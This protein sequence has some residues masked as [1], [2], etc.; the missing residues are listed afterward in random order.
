MPA[1]NRCQKLVPFIRQLTGAASGL[2]QQLPIWLLAGLLLGV[3]WWQTLGLIEDDRLR[4]ITAVER[5]L[6]NLGRANQEHAERTF[7]SADQV[8]RLVQTQYKGHKGRVTMA[9]L[10]EQG[11]FDKRIIRDVGIV[12]GAGVLRQS[13]KRLAEPI[14]VSSQ[15]YFKVHRDSGADTLFIARPAR[16]QSSGQ[17]SIALSRRVSGQGGEFDGVVV[18]ALDPTYFTQY[19][20]QIE[21][22]PQGVVSLF[23]LDGAVRARSMGQAEDFVA[24]LSASPMLSRVA[25][26]QQ[27]STLTFPGV[28]DGVE[29]TFHFRKLPS[30]PMIVA[31][32]MTTEHI[33]A[34]HMQTR[35]HLLWHAALASI[36]L[37]TL[38][39]TAS[40]NALAERRHSAAQRRALTQLQTYTNRVPGLVYEYLQRPDGSACFPFASDGIQDIL[41]LRAQDVAQ[42]AAPFFSLIHPEDLA[43]VR[44][45]LQASALALTPWECEYRVQFAEGSVRWLS[46]KALPQRL[47]DGALQWHGFMSDITDKKQAAES[48]RIAATAFESEEGVFITSAA[49][50]ILRVNQAFSRITGYQAEEVIGQKPSLLSSGRHDAAFYNA[51]R[52]SIEQSGTWHGEIWNRRKNGEVFPEWLSITAV[53][54]DDGVVT[55]HVSTLSDISKRK[56]DEAEIENLAF[57]DSLTGLPNRRLLTDRLTQAMAASTGRNSHGALLFVDL[58]HFKNLNDTQGHGQGDLLL[59]LVA[60]R[61]NHCVRESDTVARMGGDDFVIML[62]NL[63]DNRTEAAAQAEAVGQKVLETLRQPFQFSYFSYHSGASIGVALF[64]SSH[65]SV[66]ELFKRADLALYQAKNAGR[67]TLRFFEPEMQAAMTTRSEMEADLRRGL[68]ANQFVLYYQPQV[69]EQNRLTGVEALVRWQHPQRGMVSPADFIPL[70]EETGLILPLGQW[71]LETAC[72]QLKVWSTQ[73]HTA[74]LTLAVNVSASQ[75][76]SENYVQKVL[77]TIDQ[78]GAPASR[79]KLELTESLL[80]K[81]I[82]D[83]IDKMQAL[84]AR[85]VGFSLDDFGTGYSSLSHLKRLPLDQLKIDQSFLHE[86]LNNVKDAAIVRATVTLGKSLGMMVIAEGVE[87][88]AQRDFLMSEGCRN[89]QG[90]YFGRPAPVEALEPFFHIA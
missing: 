71:V 50:V 81:N 58:D 65:K 57:Y 63:S 54:D 59:Q 47:G 69:D 61:L 85:G 28:V 1:S 55:H 16:A 44:A 62:Q 79:L 17:W 21:M 64:N 22:G 25:R 89:F 90:Y 35:K 9:A 37:L 39:I 3:V 23:G 7:D 11:A 31:L 49:G 74:H 66:D 40:L 20:R 29:R 2:K 14:D 4:V 15:D 8:L 12:D 53:K 87:T 46:G 32:G 5:D 78:S 33:L 42:D 18:V 48:L 34:P 75:F 72:H 77:T 60:E 84:R 24:D 68:Q 76:Q 43:G 38:A 45:S 56:A 36:L 83:V 51:M 19:Y 86:A 67:N 10:D 82:D 26:G 27:T 70:T 80:V 88:Q 52:E 30:Y 13:S 41:R 73:P 6:V